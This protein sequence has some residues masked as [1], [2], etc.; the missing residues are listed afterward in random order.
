MYQIGIEDGEP[1]IAKFYRP[2]RWSDAAILEEHAFSLEL[3]AQEIPV[4]APLTTAER[5]LHVHQG[6]RYAVFPRRGGRWPSLASA[7]SA[8]GWA[9]SWAASMPWAG[10]RYFSNVA[11]SA[12]KAWAGTR[13]TPCS[14]ASGCRTI[15]P[16]STR[17]SPNAAAGDR[18][19]SRALEWCAAFANIGRLPSGQYSVDGRRSAF[20]RSG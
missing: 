9:A 6:F 17:M 20:R 10:P 8:N 4:V 3:A 11:R 1:V 7:T 2:N 16:K 15:W 5:T 13:A 14:T 19:Q 12:C 18:T